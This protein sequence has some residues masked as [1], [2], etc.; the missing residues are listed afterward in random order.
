VI[1]AYYFGEGILRQ[2]GLDMGISESR[3]YQLRAQALKRLAGD[4]GLADWHAA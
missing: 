1:C 4:G 2:I 3:A